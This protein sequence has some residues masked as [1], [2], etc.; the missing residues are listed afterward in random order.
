MNGILCIDKPQDFT[1]FDVV[2]VMKRLLCTRKVGHTGTLD[3]MATGVLPILAGSATRAAELLP[4]HDKEYEAGFQLGITT[5]T[6]DI[7]GTVVESRPVFSKKDEIQ[8]LLPRFTGEILQLPPMYS[9]VKKDGKRL[10]ELA[11][12]GIQMEREARKVTVFTLAL[13]GAR[14]E[15]GEYTLSISCSAGTYVRTL[16]HDLGQALGCGAVMT[17]LRRT[18]ACGFSLDDCLTLEEARA[19]SEK[20]TLGDRLLPVDAGLSG[21]PAVQ[22]TDAQFTRFRNG[23][24]LFLAR[25]NQAPKTHGAFVRVYD[26]KGK[27]AGLGMVDEN[28]Q[29]LKVKRIFSE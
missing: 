5:D 9:A 28:A 21:Y 6:Q 2:A 26:S 16:I 25:V 19:L 24:A 17:S 14:E 15:T 18:K 29:E 11:R 10:Y 13:T 1:S 4:S 23:G 3:P 12:Q 8:A 27:F 20:G 7:W 22:V